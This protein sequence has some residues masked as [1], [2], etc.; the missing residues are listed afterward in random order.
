M[1][2]RT[3]HDLSQGFINY[4]NQRESNPIRGALAEVIL[5][6][7]SA[8]ELNARRVFEQQLE[9]LQVTEEYGIFLTELTLDS[10]GQFALRQMAGVLLKQYVDVHWSIDADK[11]KP[12]EASPQTKATIRAILPHGLKESISKVR[13]S[14][15]YCISCIAHWDW[16]DEWPELFG[17][18]TTALR[19]NDAQTP[20]LVH[21]AVRVLKEFTRDLTDTQISQ[22]AP[23]IFPD[24]YRI[25][26]D[27][28]GRYTIRTRSRAIEIFTTLSSMI[29]TIGEVNKSLPKTIM[30]PVLPQF[31]EALVG[32]L[33]LPEGSH[34][35]DAGLKTAIL[36]ALTVLV[37]NVP[38]IMAPWLAQVLPPVWS[39]LTSSADLYVRE[40]VNAGDDSGDQEEIVDSD[41]EIVGFENL[42]FAIFEFVHALVE[43]PKFRPA[44]RQGLADLMYYIVLYM[45]ITNDQCEK[46]TDNPDQFVEDEDEDSFTYSVRISSQDLLTALCEEF[47]EECCVALA[48]TIQRHLNESNEMLASGNNGSKEASWK[49]REAAMLALGTAQEVIERQVA[50]GNVEFDIKGFLENVVLADLANPVSP[51]LLG[52]CLWI[53]SKFPKYLS[54]EATTH[55]SPS[56]SSNNLAHSPMGRF[57]EA[58]VRGLQADQIAV[59][60]IAAVRAIWGFC[61]HLRSS[62]SKKHLSEET[63]IERALLNPV[64][65]ATIDALINM[66]TT[67]S[68]STEI[69]GLILENMAVVL[70]CDPS[71]TASYESKVSP[72]A[73]A[74]FLKYST[75]P[76]LTSLLQ[77]IFRVIAETPQCLAPLEARLVPTLVSI[78]DA[79][80]SPDSIGSSPG[81]ESADTTFNLK[82]SVTTG[83]QAV[84]LDVLQTLVRASV[85]IPSQ[86]AS[87]AQ[88]GSS[89]TPQMQPQNCLSE[90]VINRAFPAAV[91]STLNT[92]DNA[93]MQSGGECLRAFVSV[94]PD[95]VCS[96][97]DADGKSGLWYMVQV[98]AQLLNPVGSEFTATF[99][100]RLV[101][102]LIQKTGDR[103]G[104][105]LDALLKAVLSKLQGSE[106]L[107]VIQSLLMVY[108]QLVHTQL[109]AVLRFL[110]S[111]PG[112]TGENALNFVLT[113]WV[114]RQHLFYGAYETKVS[115]VALSKLLQH[116]V[117]NNDTRLQEIN[118]KGDLIITPG[119]NTQS[120]TRSQKKSN[121]DQW[122]SVPVLVKIFK[123]LVQEI[124][125]NMDAALDCN[126]AD[127]ESEDETNNGTN[128]LDSIDAGADK[129]VHL[130]D[131]L[132]AATAAKNGTG[133]GFFDDDGLDEEEDPDALADPIYNINVCR[134][135][136]D[137][138]SEF[139]RQPF[140]AAHFAPHLNQS[141][142][143]TL[144]TIGVL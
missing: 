114:A 130:S 2:T 35:T 111:V 101:T 79:P 120:R 43:T 109:E 11:F 85:V 139:S 136:T 29:C 133:L 55:S 118:V 95:Q 93:I 24:M 144:A 28:E 68:K 15:A 6:L 138:V 17:I 71:F 63:S 142:K 46:W 73:I 134:Y 60:R 131:L 116:G 65:P 98:A 106:T 76:V 97:M 78:L 86:S 67:F 96:Y 4:T 110:C 33:S 89:Q 16:P 140:F 9:A 56:E 39:T 44:V 53:G 34:L 31:T 38:K 103:L 12:P 87:K 18:L 62:A 107:S 69:L 125:S 10:N 8:T 128:G 77:D 37:K 52:R 40:V 47:E 100:G 22:V 126:S 82:T 7:I 32:G 70:G 80:V 23:I 102:T 119:A 1:G 45:Q 122:T 135:L 48:Q 105:D 5:G 99:V 36:K 19:G 75:D 13:S 94:A 112:P 123:L 64:L 90:L 104:T 61:S 49:R 117:N 108:A 92:D 132:D 83:L 20:F 30:E 3:E 84:A 113:E 21:G 59:V 27:Q 121:P 143:T 25:F 81:A 115:I 66:C 58:T 88:E 54:R 74:I 41:G 124:T 26:V 57:V 137:F 141:E 129:M 50:A 14:V 42:V 91:R 127:E 72:L 51:F